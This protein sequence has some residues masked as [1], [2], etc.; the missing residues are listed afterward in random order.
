MVGNQLG[1][2]L[3]QFFND[4]E[5]VGP[6]GASCLRH[7]DNGISQSFDHFSLR[8]PPREF[9][10]DLDLSFGEV[11]LRKVDQFRE[12]LFPFQIF[13]VVEWESPPPPPKPIGQGT[14]LVLE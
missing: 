10:I 7:L 9:H 8:R 3:H 4:T 13:Q 5:A 6:Q 2:G 11:S 14:A 1:I 12:D